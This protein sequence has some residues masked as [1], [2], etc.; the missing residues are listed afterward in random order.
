MRLT[1]AVA[2]AATAALLLTACTGG[3]SSTGK[4]AGA[5][6]SAAVP[7]PLA[8]ASSTAAKPLATP[9]ATPTR[10][11]HDASGDV[12]PD[13]KLTP[14]QV[15]TGITTAMVCQDRV[16]RTHHPSVKTKDEV[17]ADYGIAHQDRDKYQVDQL[18][19]AA[20]GGSSNAPNLWPQ[21]RSGTNGLTKKSTLEQRLFH[22]VCTHAMTL[23]TAQKVLRTDWPDAYDKYVPKPKPKPKSTRRVQRDKLASSAP[24]AG[25]TPTPSG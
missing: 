21:P 14:G 7:T 22:L 3:D 12:L 8:A 9:T 19:P 24:S 15:L 13:P 18:I 1:I 17:L 20:L 5:S 10:F 16:P 23:G 25:S 11:T 4:P 6:T 2:G